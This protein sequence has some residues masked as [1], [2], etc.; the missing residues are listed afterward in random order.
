[1]TLRLD[2]NKIEA[3]L[4]S[5]HIGPRNKQLFRTL[6][7]R[8]KQTAPVSLYGTHVVDIYNLILINLDERLR[9]LQNRLRFGCT[10]QQQAASVRRLIPTSSSS[11][12][13]TFKADFILLFYF[14]ISGN[15][16]TNLRATILFAVIHGNS[17]LFLVHSVQHIGC[18]V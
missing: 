16:N 3:Q 7:K 14:I 13:I 10:L 9:I 12:T 15:E 17:Q 1:M 4:E 5:L 8:R 6:V 2:S 18:L 11:T